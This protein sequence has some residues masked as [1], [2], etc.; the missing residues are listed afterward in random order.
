MKAQ[1]YNFIIDDNY[2]KTLWLSGYQDL[3]PLSSVLRYQL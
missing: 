3:P 2:N 1:K